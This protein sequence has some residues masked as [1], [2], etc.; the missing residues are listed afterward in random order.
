MNENRNNRLRLALQKSGRLS[1]ESFDLLRRCGIHV[2]TRKNKLYYHSDNFPLDV[3]LVRDDDIP[4]LVHNDV[5]DLGIVGSN[6][7]EEARLSAADNTEEFSAITQQ[8]LFF[9]KCRLSIAVPEN[10]QYQ[11]TQ[12]LTNKRIATSYPAIL[13]NYLQKNNIK[14][15][16]T[17]LTGS[18]EIAPALHIADYI[19]DLVSTGATL[20]SNGLK[21]VE[22][23]FNAKALLIRAKQQLSTEK[24]KLIEQIQERLNG[25]MTA[26]EAKYI[27][28][29][30]PKP[31][32]DKIVSLLPGAE[33][34]TLLP[35]QGADDVIAVHAV[36]REGVFWETLERL[37]SQGARSILVLPIEKMLA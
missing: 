22:T 19:C 10:Q 5:C 13:K 12:D 29:H 7:M 9:G 17:M 28:L 14:A 3:L 21:E 11:S 1:Q 34:P 31:S 32:L 16:V 33:H 15:Q 30:A 23:I 24:E 20:E 26:N 18:V 4:E 2:N 8:P 25:V 27:M 36:C 35:L 37:K 6:V